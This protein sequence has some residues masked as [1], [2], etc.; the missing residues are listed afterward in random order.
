MTYDRSFPRTGLLFYGLLS[1]RL[2]IE[3]L[4][5]LIKRNPGTLV[6]SL[7]KEKMVRGVFEHFVDVDVLDYVRKELSHRDSMILCVETQELCCRRIDLNF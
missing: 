3:T 2:R 7:R 1:F 4:H 5:E 6:F